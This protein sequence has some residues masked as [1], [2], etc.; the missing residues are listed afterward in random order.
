MR[1]A[2]GA[3]G[4]ERA[5]AFSMEVR[6]PDDGNPQTAARIREEASAYLLTEEEIAAQ[7]AEG[8]RRVERWLEQMA[9]EDDG[10]AE[11]GPEQRDQS[12]DGA[13]GDGSRGKGPRSKR[14]R[15]PGASSGDDAA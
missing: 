9:E 1:S 10:N 8:R 2:P 15:P 14:T 3:V 11:S 5:P 4:T 6:K 7:R 12:R 13:S